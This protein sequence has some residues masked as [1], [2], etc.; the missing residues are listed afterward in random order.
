L[1]DITGIDIFGNISSAYTEIIAKMDP[2]LEA[3]KPL[4]IPTTWFYISSSLEPI[5]CTL[6]GFKIVPNAI[7]EDCPKDLDIIVQGGSIETGEGAKKFMRDAWPK[8]RVWMTTCVGSTWLASS[9]VL[10]GYKATTNCGFLPFAKKTY[11]DVEW[12]DQRWVVDE[13][14]YDGEG[15]GELW[16]AGGAGVGKSA[17]CVVPGE[18]QADSV[19]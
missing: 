18:F 5:E 9:G 13:K 4:S 19:L 12:V 11:T 2:R 10:K 1:S 17:R 7:Y 3:L 8:T 14:L 16:T 15:K 6:Q